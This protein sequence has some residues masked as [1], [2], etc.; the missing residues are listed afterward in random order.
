MS[1]LI[2]GTAV[3]SIILIIL[4]LALYNENDE[5]KKIRLEDRN[6][7]ITQL[8][9]TNRELAILN[10][11]LSK[12]LAN[13]PLTIV[14]TKVIT[15]VKEIHV[16]NSVPNTQY[17]RSPVLVTLTLISSI[18]LIVGGLFLVFKFYIYK[19]RKTNY[20]NHMRMLEDRKI[21]KVDGQIIKSYKG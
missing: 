15:I 18:G 1:P 14:E 13:K 10:Q 19:K 16:I 21:V 3:I 5:L 7:T 2:N 11:D 12:E 17:I 8:E 9:K 6:N 4:L 20:E